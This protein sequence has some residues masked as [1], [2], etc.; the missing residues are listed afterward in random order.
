MR[1]REPRGGRSTVHILTHR[2]GG[3]TKDRVLDSFPTSWPCS[4]RITSSA[5]A[6]SAASWL[7]AYAALFALANPCKDCVRCVDEK[8]RQQPAR[9]S[10]AGAA[11][12][13]SVD[14]AFAG[15]SCDS[16]PPRECPLP[17]ACTQAHTQRG[18]SFGRSASPLQSRM[19]RIPRAR[20]K[21]FNVHAEAVPG[22]CMRQ[23]ATW[24]ARRTHAM[25]TN[26]LLPAES[27]RCAA[28]CISALWR[29]FRNHG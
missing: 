23:M 4:C 8:P 14:T 25:L 3:Q 27:A 17:A 16:L 21:A 6:A 9:F 26:P 12:A 28:C 10:A 15:T 22:K 29:W 13:A 11:L 7:S 2:G 5:H 19:S 24:A 1:K 18:A 20:C